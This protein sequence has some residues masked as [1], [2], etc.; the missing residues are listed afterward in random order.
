[1]CVNGIWYCQRLI[2]LL[3][4]PF[5]VNP[6]R[7]FHVCVCMYDSVNRQYIYLVPKSKVAKR[8]RQ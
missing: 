4:S 5:D 3:Q 6:S 1:M 7:P 8:S 2:V